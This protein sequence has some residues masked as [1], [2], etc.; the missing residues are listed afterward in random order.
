[1][2]EHEQRYVGDETGAQQAGDGSGARQV[3]EERGV[4]GAGDGSGARQVGEDRSVGGA[5]DGSGAGHSGDEAG[6]RGPGDETGGRGTAGGAGM[7]PLLPEADVQA[8]SRRWHEIQ[9]GFVD[10]PRRA[11]ADADALVGVLVQQISRLFD[12]ERAQFE[13]LWDRGEHV[14]TEELRVGLQQYRNFFER[15]LST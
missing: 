2:S 9:S 4:G 14:S 13:A 15:L 10:D 11:V 6:A 7:A 12:N 3:G 1:M 5:G 8:A